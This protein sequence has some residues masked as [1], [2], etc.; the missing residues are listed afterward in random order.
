MSQ[1][2]EFNWEESKIVTKHRKYAG[3]IYDPAVI[4]YEIE[5]DTVKYVTDSGVGVYPYIRFLF[6][7]FI[8]FP[9]DAD[10]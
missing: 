3:F 4:L 5:N 10:L 8:D 1:Y 2:I 6:W 7:K 9:A